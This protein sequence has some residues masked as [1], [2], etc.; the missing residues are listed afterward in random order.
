MRPA[1]ARR[2]KNLVQLDRIDPE[3]ARELEVHF[4]PWA[5]YLAAALEKRL[6]AAVAGISDGYVRWLTLVESLDDLP[7]VEPVLDFVSRKYVH[8]VAV[9]SK[10][11]EVH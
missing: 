5:T 11:S 2:L 7:G 3:Q 9:L 6:P 1:Q 4:A 8:S 10:S